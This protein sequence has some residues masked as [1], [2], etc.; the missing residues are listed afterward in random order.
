MSDA[1]LRG[2]CGGGAA[3]IIAVDATGLASEVARR[4]S[5]GPRARALAAEALVAAV[6]LSSWIK[7]E[8][9]LTLQIQS[10]RP[11]FGFI[12]DVDA[13]GGLRARMTPSRLR[14]TSG[15]AI[16][17]LMLTI[18]S[19]P[20]A[21]VYRGMTELAGGSLQDALRAHLRQSSQV[22]TVFRIAADMGA[23]S[24]FAGGVL[25]ERLP[26]TDE[27]PSMS[28]ASFQTV[29]GSLRDLDTALESAALAT[30]LE[31]EAFQGEPIL[32]ATREPLRWRCGCGLERVTAVLAQLPV[33]DLQQML[34][35][36]GGAEVTCHFCVEA[37]R[38]GPDQLREMIARR[39]T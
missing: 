38:L 30:L 12:A 3:R 19:L 33:A 24:P 14:R 11:R 31:S 5:L 1:I 34:D 28:S 32:S 7:G 25:I 27:L 23:E 17:G 2:I 22:D 21:E 4:H 10:K 29:F 13:S 35:E 18:K 15:S 6:F 20:Q 36:D 37:W 39:T 9:R 16:Q 26:E 8:E